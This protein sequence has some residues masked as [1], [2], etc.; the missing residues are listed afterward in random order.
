M[1]SFKPLIL[2]L[3]LLDMTIGALSQ[4][5]GI[6]D[7]VKR[8][9]PNHVDSFESSLVDDG[10]LDSKIPKN[11][12]FVVSTTP[13]GKVWVDGNSLSALSSGY[14]S[15]FGVKTWTVNTNT[16]CRLSKYLTDV[17]HVDIHWFI[18]NRLDQAP[19]ELPALAEPLKG[20]S[21]VSWRYHF[22]TGAASDF[23]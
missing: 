3:G 1:K 12:E 2:G 18:G 11:A 23:R 19:V 5:E 9:L 15:Q 14:V 6:Y 13:E 4:P 16:L 7:L 22:N 17:V 20:S 8:R 10:T 21:V